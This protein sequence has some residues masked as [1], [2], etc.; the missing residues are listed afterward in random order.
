ML[1]RSTVSPKMVKKYLAEERDKRTKL[2][3]K[4]VKACSTAKVPKLITPLN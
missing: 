2:L 1:P 4:Y 3:E